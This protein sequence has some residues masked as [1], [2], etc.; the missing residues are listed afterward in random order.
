MRGGGARGGVALSLRLLRRAASIVVV[1]TLTF[2]GL[3]LATFVIGRV[4]PID[5]VLAAVGDRATAEVYQRTRIQLGL[6]LPLYEQFYHYVEKVLHGDLGRSVLTSNAVLADV[7]HFFPATLELA[8]LA[9]LFGVA[10]GVPLGVTAAANQGRWQDQGIRIGGLRGY[11]VPVFWLGLVGL[12]VFYARLGW[13][14]GPGRLDVGYDDIIDSVTRLILVDSLIAGEWEGFVNALRHIILP[15][16]LLVY[17]SPAYISPIARHLMLE[18][19][20]QEHVV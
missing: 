7:T 2:F 18:Q 20:R 14:A 12:L 11:S 6:A 13:V 9:T 4:M 16:R 1:V 15:A 19:L 10:L 5:P 17:S 3:L 8:T